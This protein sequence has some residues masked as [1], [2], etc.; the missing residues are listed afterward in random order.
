LEGELVLERDEGE[1]V[2]TPG[3]VAGFKAGEA[4]GHCLV[5]KSDKTAIYL[6]IGDRREGDSGEY[7][8]A[9]L[10]AERHEGGW[11]FTHKD[12]TPY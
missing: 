1:Q 2:L 7:S 11:R 8:E 10:K 9:D 3:M 5:N 4:N 6:E 12:G